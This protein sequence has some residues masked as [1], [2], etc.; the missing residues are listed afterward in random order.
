MRAAALLLLSACNSLYGLDETMIAEDDSGGPPADARC[1]TAGEGPPVYR[2]AVTEITTRDCVDYT[3]SA[4][5]RAV[6]QCLDGDNRIEEG[7]TEGELA[8]V[9]LEGTIATAFVSLPRITPDGDQL[10]VRQLESGS[11]GAQHVS[12]F[13]RSP[14]GWT[15]NRDIVVVNGFIQFGTPSSAPDR[16]ILVTDLSMVRELAEQAD[17]WVEIRSQTWSSL[18]PA[19]QIGNTPHLSAD[20]LRLT[21]MAEDQLYYSYRA[22]RDEAFPPAE[23]IASAGEGRS[24]FFS[25][26]CGTLYFSGL[27]AVYR[28]YQE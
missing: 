23:L 1:P 13:D 6:A 24:P 15:F 9:I 27:G 4:S 26:D 12:L 21:F 5:G 19:M 17:S 16:R 3:L 22:S 20:A 14:S 10:V 8:P 11:A 28:R 2:R 25:D 7:P 18:V